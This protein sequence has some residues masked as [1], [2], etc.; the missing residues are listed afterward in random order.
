MCRFICAY[1]QRKINFDSVYAWELTPLL[2]SEYWRN[3]PA[4]FK[5]FWHFYNTPIKS[6]KN[7]AD[8]PFRY[9]QQIA[10]ENDFVSMKLDI[11]SP[12]TEIPLFEQLVHESDG[13]YKLV[14]EFFFELHYRCSRSL[15]YLL[16]VVIA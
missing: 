2:P 3:V 7:H 8:S 11:D 15:T 14:D 1:S 4:H 10:T 6:S 12:S 5:P 13:T 9:L 16:P